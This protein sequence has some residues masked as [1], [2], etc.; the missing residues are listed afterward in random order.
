MFGFG[1]NAVRSVPVD[2]RGCMITSELE[3]MVK[4]AKDGGEVPFYVNSTAGTTVLGSF[5]PIDEIA[6]V[7]E[8]EKLW[9]HIDG[10]WGGP[11]VFSEKLKKARLHGCERADSIAITPHKMLGVPLTCSFLLGK[12]IRQFHK[13]N[14]LP[15]G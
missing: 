9:L 7:C 4:K 6:D 5:D 10:S 8:R 15:A 2:E 1:S 12:D 14:T 13:A 11:F 3:R